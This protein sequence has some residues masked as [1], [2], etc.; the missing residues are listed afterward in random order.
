MLASRPASNSDAMHS[1]SRETHRSGRGRPGSQ[2]TRE[3]VRRRRH[4]C[5]PSNSSLLKAPCRCFPPP[6][7]PPTLLSILR[8]P[9]KLQQ[10]QQEKP[11]VPRW[12]TRF[13]VLLPLPLHLHHHDRTNYLPLTDKAMVLRAARFIPAA[14]PVLQQRQGEG[15]RKRRGNLAEMRPG[16]G[17]LE[18]KSG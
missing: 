13:R 5:L 3:A 8:C 9:P 6:P 7:N 15:R 11:S 14:R 4:R 2:E 12:P 18:P 1:F 10:Q 16:A 17:L